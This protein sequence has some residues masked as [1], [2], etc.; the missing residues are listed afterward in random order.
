M[1]EV[2]PVDFNHRRRKVDQPEPQAPTNENV[3]LFGVVQ[4]LEEDYDKLLTLGSLGRKVMRD[5]FDACATSVMAGFTQYTCGVVGC[6]A[7]CM[8][9]NTGNADVIDEDQWSQ[10]YGACTDANK[11]ED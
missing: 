10:M 9:E 2:I 5:S 4:Y 6:A 8:I 3:C 11:L 7:Q 1:G